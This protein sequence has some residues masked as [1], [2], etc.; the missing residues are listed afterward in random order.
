MLFYFGATDVGCFPGCVRAFRQTLCAMVGWPLIGCDSDGQGALAVVRGLWVSSVMSAEV[1]DC[2]KKEVTVNN[3]LHA[4]QDV[5][6]IVKLVSAMNI[7][8][9]TIMYLKEGG[10]L[11]GFQAKTGYVQVSERGR[12][13]GVFAFHGFSIARHA[14]ARAWCGEKFHNFSMGKENA[15]QVGEI[16]PENGRF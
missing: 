10:A 9:G 13:E 2:S 7:P 14:T 16:C 3:T 6:V 11:S 5:N 4:R 12:W 1:H 15:A 8:R